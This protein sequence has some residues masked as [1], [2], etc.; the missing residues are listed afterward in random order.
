MSDPD[1]DTGRGQ[2]RGSDEG[3]KPLP[4]PRPA[5]RPASLRELFFAFNRLAL[6]GFGGVLPVAHR[7]LVERRSWLSPGQF[8]ELLALGPGRPHRPGHAPKQG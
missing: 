2:G 7:E 8:V 1:S 6:Q 3:D 4:E 5:S